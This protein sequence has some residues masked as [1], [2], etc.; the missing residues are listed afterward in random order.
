[1]K[2]LFLLYGPDGPLPEPGTAEHAAMFERWS[3]ATGAMAQAGVLDR[4]RAGPARL[5]VDDPAGQERRG[6]ADRAMDEAAA[7]RIS[8]ELSCSAA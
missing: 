1:M 7:P 5:G 3:A 4:L 2:Y 8:P 6:G